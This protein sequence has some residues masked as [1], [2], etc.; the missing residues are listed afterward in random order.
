MQKKDTLRE[1]NY[2]PLCAF[3]TIHITFTYNVKSVGQR[4]APILPSRM[5]LKRGTGGLTMTNADKI[6]SLNDE[7]LENFLRNIKQRTKIA[8]SIYS[9]EVFDELCNLTWL[10]QEVLN[11]N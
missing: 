3:L 9:Q 4:V 2:S 10:Q 11:E 5:Q 7:E 8:L 6:R 1:R